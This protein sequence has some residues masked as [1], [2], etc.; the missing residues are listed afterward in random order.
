M[1]HRITAIA[2]AAFGVSAAQAQSIFIDF[3][4]DAHGNIIRAGQVLDSEYSG[5]G[6]SIKANNFTGPDKAIAFDS[7]NP[8]GGDT[9]L[10]TKNQGNVLII[11]ENDK[12]ANKDGLVDVPDDEGSRPS[13]W[14]EFSFA[15][16]ILSG[17]LSFIDIEEKGGRID[18][19]QGSNQVNEIAIAAKGDNSFQT[20]NWS[21]FTYDRMRVNLAGSGAMD[22]LR[23]E[24]VPEPATMIGLGAAAAFM[25]RRRRR[26]A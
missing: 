18:F 4:R 12:D 7:Q 1:L 5:V 10:R 22:D 20:L 21:G 2:L 6:V 14:V 24:A 3:D 19:F 15:Q 16:D 17:G 23:A 26:Q 9:D 13:G 11:A 8:T 25:A